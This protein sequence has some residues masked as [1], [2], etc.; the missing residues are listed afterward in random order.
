[1]VVI[2][3]ERVSSSARG[4]LS[5]WLVEVKSG[6]FVGRISA[7]V[8]EKLWE[9]ICVP[10]GGGATLIYTT[11][12]EQGFTVKTNGKSRYRIVDLEGVFLAEAP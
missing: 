3:M 12:T 4:E 8:R 7:V 10:A 9:R 2:L 5:R 1:M 6:V 11:N